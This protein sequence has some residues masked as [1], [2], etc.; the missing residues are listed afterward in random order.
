M[1]ISD[2]ATN[3]AG[4][5]LYPIREVSRLTGVN[6]VT[7]RA[8][9]RRYGLIRP[10]RT[11]K[12]HRLYARGDIERIERILHWLS[13]GVSVSQVGDLLEQPESDEASATTDGD[14]PGQRQQLITAIQALDTARLESLYNQSLALYPVDVCVNE[15]WQPVIAQLDEHWG[16]YH[17]DALQRHTLEAFL[18]TR[19][20]TRLYH[21]NLTA[22]GPQLLL[23]P[24]PESGGP[25]WLLLFALAASHAGYR[26]QMMD[27][28]LP[29][30]ELPLAIEHLRLA[31]VV[32]IGNQGEHSEL[33]QRQLP[34]LAEQLSAPLYLAGTVVHIHAADLENSHVTLLGDEPMQAATR[35]RSM[36]LS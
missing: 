15:L 7:L 12:G 10:Q 3:P 29:H 14:W 31:A 16:G 18:R 22:R 5:P 27:S 36:L 34:H 33:V 19:I 4:A 8:W 20:G 9:E 35:L 13:R 23:A 26:V 24:L 21:A 30:S 1:G 32:L 17:G 25:L 11:P 2:M 6:S 28:P